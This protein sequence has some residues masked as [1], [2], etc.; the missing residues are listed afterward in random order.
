MEKINKE[1]LSNSEEKKEETE[2]YFIDLNDIEG[3]GGV[4][5]AELDEVLREKYPQKEKEGEPKQEENVLEQ[6]AA[7]AENPHFMGKIKEKLH[8]VCKRSLDKKTYDDFSK[9]FKDFWSKDRESLIVSMGGKISYDTLSSLTGTK[10]ITDWALYGLHKAGI[11]S[12]I[13]GDVYKYYAE[14]D[15]ERALVEMTN[16]S[17]DLREK[18]SEDKE[19]LKENEEFKATKEKLRSAT[20]NFK[21]KVN[22]LNVPDDKKKALKR[23]LAFIMTEHK[24]REESLYKGQSEQ[25]EGVMRNYTG[26]K[27]NAF[28][29]GKDFTNS[30]LTLSGFMALRG[31]SYVGFSALE[32]GKTSWDKYSRE[33]YVNQKE[34]GE[35]IEWKSSYAEISTEKMK[36]VLK[37]VTIDSAKETCAELVK[38]QKNWES[39]EDLEDRREEKKQE[40]QESLEKLKEQLE[41]EGRGVF[42]KTWKVAWHKMKNVD[43]D[44]VKSN[45]VRLQALGKLTRVFGI[46]VLGY[47]AYESDGNMFQG[48]YD[49]LIDGIQEK[50]YSMIGDNMFAAVDRSARVFDTDKWEKAWED[51][52]SKSVNLIAGEDEGVGSG[53]EEIVHK[54]TVKISQDK[55]LRT[56]AG[57][58]QEK[59]IIDISTLEKSDSLVDFQAP[60][61]EEIRELS[62]IIFSK[63]GEDLSKFLASCSQE[64]LQEILAH[65]ELYFNSEISEEQFSALVDAAY[66]E[67]NFSSNVDADSLNNL[68]LAEVDGEDSQSVK[69]AFDPEDPWEQKKVIASLY[70]DMG[71]K[72]SIKSEFKNF[73][74]AENVKAEKG[75]SIWTMAE[76]YLEGNKEFSNLKADGN[77][78]EA[79]ETY[80]IDRI[81]DKIVANPEEYGL[82]KKVNFDKLSTK[83]LEE[84]NWQ[85]AFNDTFGEEGVTDNLNEE[86]VEGVIASNEKMKNV[87]TESVKDLEE[88]EKIK[89]PEIKQDEKNIHI[90]NGL[91]IDRDSQF[92]DEW[93]TWK[94]M[95]AQK[96]I[97]KDYGEAI[98]SHNIPEENRESQLDHPRGADWAEIKHRELLRE[99]IMNAQDLID[100]P[101]DAESIED[102]LAKYNLR[103]AEA[104]KSLFENL[105]DTDLITHDTEKN[106]IIFQ[107]LDKMPGSLKRVL[108]DDFENN[109]EIALGYINLLS[110]DKSEVSQGIQKL[111]S[112]SKGIN[113][114]D[115]ILKSDGRC[116]YK[117]AFGC[118]NYDLIISSDRIGVDGP[119]SNNWNVA[120]L[121]GQN[122]SAK[123]NLE[124][125]QNSKSWILN[126]S[127]GGKARVEVP[128]EKEVDSQDIV[129]ISS[130]EDG[131]REIIDEKVESIEDQIQ[132]IEVSISDSEKQK[133][134]E[135]E[136]NYQYFYDREALS[137]ELNKLSSPNYQGGE[138]DVQLKALKKVLLQQ[139]QKG[140]EGIVDLTK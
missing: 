48:A 131:E 106:S 75:D 115:I 22:N 53:V 52:R 9:K 126:D 16:N 76:K 34:A 38:G 47:E 56:G 66:R 32:K 11:K 123:L 20:K 18:Y 137:R 41:E 59:P 132:K 24:R 54:K 61:K 37:G 101:R 50:D 117:N 27:V 36:Q 10:A 7:I 81:K 23:E 44:K 122:P 93:E 70:D 86:Q 64:E 113:S 43:S 139:G 134:S 26:A 98:N 102:Y 55:L 13:K 39:P 68:R 108:I 118:K 119:W 63:S 60:V 65:E 97:Y 83:Q 19:D 29:L 25:F 87:Q 96:F 99:R 84:I 85:K 140:E 135:W 90:D 4:S 62:S 35:E 82:D 57:K 130:E 67:E 125:I 114:E 72:E 107:R 77:L 14:N 138:K 103:N 30:A 109:K 40:K 112:Y 33:V 127:R 121:R 133:F 105:K 5:Q 46:S 91:V 100:A 74:I 15:M 88:M 28:K 92:A 73:V 69:F 6:E 17:V 1:N 80:N 42:G 124:N 129:D 136:K 110:K 45:L 31:A 49:R 79:L 71:S 2:E 95:E 51:V 21:D 111:F 116:I 94:S 78:E 128:T 3:D 12:S 89:V 58:E 8:Q 120:G 104:N